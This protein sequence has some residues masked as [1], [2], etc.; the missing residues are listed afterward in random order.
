MHN[1]FDINLC[2]L[3]RMKGRVLLGFGVATRVQVLE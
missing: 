3:Q 2:K 1:L